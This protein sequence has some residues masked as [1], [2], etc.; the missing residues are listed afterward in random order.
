[1]SKVAIKRRK[2]HYFSRFTTLIS[3]QNVLKLLFIND[4]RQFKPLQNR[5]I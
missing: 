5:F 4:L 2:F 3:L 1:M